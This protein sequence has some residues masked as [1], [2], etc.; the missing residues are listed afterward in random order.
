MYFCFIERIS[1]CLNIFDDFWCCIVALLIWNITCISLVTIINLYYLWKCY[2]YEVFDFL[3][4]FYVACLQKRVFYPWSFPFNSLNGS[5][6]A[7]ITFYPSNY[8]YEMCYPII[9][10]TWNSFIHWN[11]LQ[12]LLKLLNF[13]NMYEEHIISKIWCS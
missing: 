9:S 8:L 12:I 6:D 11:L 1:L 5:E 3:T 13:L 2:N 7:S 10:S 4:H